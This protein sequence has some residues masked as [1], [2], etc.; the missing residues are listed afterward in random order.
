MW[1]QEYVERAH[2]GSMRQGARPG[3]G[4][5]LHPHGHMVRPPGVFSVTIILKY[6]KKSY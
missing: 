4:H 6:S 2:V 3:G 1:V 5:A